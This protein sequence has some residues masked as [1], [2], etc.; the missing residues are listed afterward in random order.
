[1]ALRC[2]C[3]VSPAKDNNT[4]GARDFNVRFAPNSV[5]CSSELALLL[6]CCICVCIYIHIC[7]RV[8]LAIYTCFSTI[9][10]RSQRSSGTL[11]IF[12]LFFVFSCAPI[13]LYTYINIYTYTYI[14]TY[15]FTYIYSGNEITKYL[16]AKF[17]LFK[18]KLSLNLSACTHIY[19]HLHMYVHMY[20]IYIIIMFVC[21]T[22]L[23]GC[24]PQKS[25]R[26]LNEVANVY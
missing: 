1:M 12:A 22:S 8:L 23:V 16:T 25:I 26:N 10:R 15:V 6:C 19:F 13:Y 7:V 3:T 21:R 18:C 5:R 11:G 17:D 24:R 20:T 9:S 4:N 14:S 2:C